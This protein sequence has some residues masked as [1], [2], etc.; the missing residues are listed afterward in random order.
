MEQDLLSNISVNF[1]FSE[2]SR[3]RFSLIDEAKAF[4]IVS[5]IKEVASASQQAEHRR[6]DIDYNEI[7]RFVQEELELEHN[8]IT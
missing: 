1:L 2:G 6:R 5:K 4:K 3:L 8:H 7:V